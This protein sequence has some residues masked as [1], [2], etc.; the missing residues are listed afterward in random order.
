MGYDDIRFL[1]QVFK[2]FID[3]RRPKGMKKKQLDPYNLLLSTYRSRFLRYLWLLWHSI[4]PNISLDSP[5]DILGITTDRTS[6][7]LYYHMAESVGK[8]LNE[9]IF[10]SEEKLEITGANKPIMLNVPSSYGKWMSI[11]YESDSHVSSF[12]D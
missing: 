10:H 9:L 12:L 2:G 8:W 4:I 6:Y 5:R 1:R 3:Y 11:N 7:D